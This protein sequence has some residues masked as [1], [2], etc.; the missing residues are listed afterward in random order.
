MKLSET[1][2]LILQQNAKMRKFIKTACGAANPYPGPLQEDIEALYRVVNLVRQ[3]EPGGEVMTLA[4][5][6][7]AL[8]NQIEFTGGT[9]NE[10]Q[11]PGCF[12]SK[13]RFSRH[14]V[15]QADEAHKQ[16][17][18]LVRVRELAR[19]TKKEEEKR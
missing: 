6:V 2:D 8:L 3:Y 14:W 9:K 7:L 18:N 16:P 1:I 15:A 13:P 17:C 19:Q 12:A 5:E 10:A 4:A 11:C